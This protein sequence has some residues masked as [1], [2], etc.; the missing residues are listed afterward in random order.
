VELSLFV[1]LV[2]DDRCWFVLK[3][4]YWLLVADFLSEKY[5][6]LVADKSNQGGRS[7]HAGC[8]RAQVLLFGPNC[9]LALALY[10]SYDALALYSSYDYEQCALA[11]TCA[12]PACRSAA[13]H[14]ARMGRGRGRGRKEGFPNCSHSPRHI[15]DGSDP[16][17]GRC[18]WYGQ[19]THININLLLDHCLSRFNFLS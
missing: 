15:I 18:A 7:V 11:E 13:A 14:G 17:R 12:V 3:E 6:W 19:R 2:A 10:S 1:W 8:T 4:K 16:C 9:L 5:C